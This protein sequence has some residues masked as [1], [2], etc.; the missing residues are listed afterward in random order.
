MG[1]KHSALR[2]ALTAALAE[3][4]GGLKVKPGR[5]PVLDEA[6]LEAIVEQVRAG[7]PPAVAAVACGMSKRSHM[8]YMRI[9][10][11]ENEAF[12]ASV[13]ECETPEE[14]VELVEAFNASRHWHY[15]RK[16]T[17]AEALFLGLCTDAVAGAIAN[18]DSDLALKV[19]ER[20]DPDNWKVT[21]AKDVRLQNHDGTGNAVVGVDLS[22]LS[23]DQLAALASDEDLGEDFD[24]DTDDED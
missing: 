13:D 15:W 6:K 22:N 20:R 23:P 7:L 21:Q 2:K 8:R 3:Q 9:G 1:D 10:R 11:E 12:T 16:V 18:G 14:I 24:L 4:D 5:P 19:L 17:H